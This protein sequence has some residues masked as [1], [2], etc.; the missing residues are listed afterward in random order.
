MNKIPHPHGLKDCLQCKG[1]G[2]LFFRPNKKRIL[3]IE[4]DI[5][6]GTGKADRSDLWEAIGLIIK[7]WRIENEIGIRE[8]SRRFKIDPS[9]LSKMERG[10][11]KPNPEYV[12][13]VFKN[14]R[15][16]T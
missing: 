16:F 6:K 10:I 13:M 5:C 8:A 12:K 1:L 2:K 11:I 14:R 15:A 3:Y 9:N 7:D 4:C